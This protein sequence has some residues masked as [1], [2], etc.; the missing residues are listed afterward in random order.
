MVG[1]AGVYR[2]IESRYFESV[3]IIQPLAR[4]DSLFFEGRNQLT[5]INDATKLG[6]LPELRKVHLR[7]DDIEIRVWRGFS[8]DPLEG[9]ILSRTDGEWSALHI[10]TDNCCRFEKATVEPLYRPKLGWSAFWKML[11]EKEI[12]TIP[13]SSENECDKPGIDE[14]GYVVEINQGMNYR[15]YFYPQSGKCREAKQTK[16]IGE[17]IGLEFDSGQEQCERT[18]W[19][20]CMTFLKSRN[21]LSQ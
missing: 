12:L 17:I 18:E 9:V 8:L 2:L 6:D 10:K 19:F 21:L 14:I 1:V 13:Q 7:K 16:E 5:G 11:D 20:A 3:N 4:P 15:N